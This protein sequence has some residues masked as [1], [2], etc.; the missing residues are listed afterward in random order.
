MTPGG[1]LVAKK[2]ALLIGINEY[3]PAIGPLAGCINDVRQVKE[4]L[5]GHFSFPSEEVKEL[6]D[7]D[8]TR[9]AILTGLE[10]L[11][12]DA[13]TGDV[14]VLFYSGHGTRLHNPEDPSGKDEALVAYSDEWE[15]LLDGQTYPH[16][17]FLEEDWER[18]FIRDKEIKSCLNSLADGVNLTLI[19]DCCHSGDIS[20]IPRRFPRFVE[21]PTSVQNAIHEAARSYQEGEQEEGDPDE[22]KISKEHVKH[23]LEKVFLGNRFDFVDSLERSILLAACSEKETAIE[24]TFDGERGGVFTHYL[25]DALRSDGGKMTYNDLIEK[26]GHKM[27]FA[28][29][30]MPRLMC[31]DQ[32]RHQTVLSPLHTG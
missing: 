22:L 29:P 11:V 3:H 27:R 24:K 25:A 23:W 7:S 17:L 12:G 30:Q 20:K 13:E 8:A 18:Q 1:R 14:L 32:N 31:S 5:L 15:H 4:I 9:E 2:R 16:A 26:V 21:P 28:S 6:H 10:W 19:M